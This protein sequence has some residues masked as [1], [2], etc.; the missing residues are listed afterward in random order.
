MT[1]E[2]FVRKLLATAA[3]RWPGTTLAQV[4]AGAIIYRTKCT[5]CHANYVLSNFTEDRLNYEFTRMTRLA[6]LD[7]EEEVQ[8]IRYVLSL[9]DLEISRKR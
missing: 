8:I 3:A 1:E 6:E 4:K 5:R 7:P 2:E 9:R